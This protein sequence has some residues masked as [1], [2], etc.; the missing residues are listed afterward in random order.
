MFDAY[1][2]LRDEKATGTN[3]GTFTLGAWRTRDLNTEASDPDGILSIANNQFTLQ[4]GTYFLYARAPAALV[5]NHQAKLRNVTDGA[6][7]LI[8]STSYGPASGGQHD[9]IVQ[10]RFTIAA[11]K[12]FEIQHQ[13]QLTQAANGFGDAASFATEVYT[14]VQIWREA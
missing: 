7:V 4:A 5:G 14:E 11:A 2:L 12:A 1:A 9:S 8:G 10:G 6:D 13:S 3:G